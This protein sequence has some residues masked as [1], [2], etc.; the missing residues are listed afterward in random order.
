MLSSGRFDVMQTASAIRTLRATILWWCVAVT[1]TA[2]V[3]ALGTATWLAERI[4]R[5][6]RLL[7]AQ[8]ALIGLA[9]PTPSFSS[10]RGDEIGA[11]ARVLGTMVRRLRAASPAC[12]MQSGARWS[13]ISRAR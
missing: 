11:L 3:A 7:A 5:P 9:S 6:I 1:A 2:A 8:S 13:G 10:D 12:G 4:S